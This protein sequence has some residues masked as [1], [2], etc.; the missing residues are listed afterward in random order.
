LTSEQFEVSSRGW[1]GSLSWS[2]LQ[3]TEFSEGAVEFE[4]LSFEFKYKLA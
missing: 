3:I 2:F 1:K 4:P